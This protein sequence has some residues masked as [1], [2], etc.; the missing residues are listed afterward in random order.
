MAKFD[1]PLKGKAQC[2]HRHSNQDI[3]RICNQLS[4]VGEITHDPPERINLY[5]SMPFSDV[6]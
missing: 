6:D 5:T 1:L 2:N 3:A 4:A